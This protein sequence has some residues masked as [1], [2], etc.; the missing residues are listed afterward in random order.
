M[1]RKVLILKILLKCVLAAALF[2]CTWNF[3]TPYF[4]ESRSKEGD[5]FHNLPADSIDVLALG[6][7]HIQYAFNPGVFYAETGDYSYVLGSQCQPMSMS[8]YML[9]EALKT[10]HPSVVIIDVFTLLNQSAICYSEGMYY[11]AIQQMTGN[12]RRQAAAELSDGETRLSY[13]YDFLM[14]HSNWKT[15]DWSDWKS[16]LARGRARSGLLSDLGYV[17][18]EPVS[19]VHTPLSVPQADGSGSLSE[20]SRGDLDRIISLCQDSGIHL[21]FIKTPYTIDQADANQ[22]AAVWDYLDSRNVE[23]IDFIAKAAE[24][25]WF[26]DLDGDTW[27][28]NSW[29]SEIVTRYLAKT[30]T[31]EGL[32]RNHQENE[33]VEAQLRK[34]V[35]A[36]AASLMNAHNIDVYSMLTFAAKYPCTVAVRYSG[37]KTTSIT[38]V[39]NLMLQAAGLNHDFVKDC[40]EDYYALIQDGKVVKESDEPFE[41][42]LNGTDIAVAA[43]SIT[44]NGSPQ[45]AA[46]E[47]E[48]C[49]CSDDFSW[50]NPI[51]ID[52]SS[53]Y[54]WKNGCSGWDCA[55]GS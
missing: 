8:F 28:N 7:S 48:L 13:Q 37:K 14:N 38:S 53:R 34:S 40:A 23:H 9:E 31:E 10:Q 55:A 35:S 49:F 44:I 26:S 25:N 41:T 54:F 1:K 32:I 12:T 18:Q 16:I 29:G 19:D 22:L 4:R 42:S 24:L 36:D 45:G 50:L 6:S 30:I 2:A 39:E 5:S 21:I 46:G 27:H 11:L 3:L 17:R 51:S 33:T 52:Y 47:M 20:Q 43:D 15:M